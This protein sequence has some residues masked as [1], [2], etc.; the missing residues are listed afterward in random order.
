M[1]YTVPKAPLRSLRVVCL[2]RGEADAKFETM[3][4]YSRDKSGPVRTNVYMHMLSRTFDDQKIVIKATEAPT[5]DAATLV[6][7]ELAAPITA[8]VFT[9]N[10]RAEYTYVLCRRVNVHGVLNSDAVCDL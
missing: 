9:D 5:L 2:N 8:P 6:A 7:L 1:A 4:M 3:L 10:N